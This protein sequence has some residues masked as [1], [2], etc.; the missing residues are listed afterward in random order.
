M[1][2]SE[3]FKKACLIKLVGQKRK[4]RIQSNIQTFFKRI[5]AAL[6]QDTVDAC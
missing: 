2:L 5:S 3:A 1:I 4:S 6:G